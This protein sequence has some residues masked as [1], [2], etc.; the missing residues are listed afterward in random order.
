MSEPTEPATGQ[1]EL[2]ECGHSQ[3]DHKPCG[4]QDGGAKWV[5]FATD[6]KNIPVCDCESYRQIPKPTPTD[7]KTAR[8]FYEQYFGEIGHGGIY[9]A[10]TDYA[11]HVL[12]GA[13]SVDRRAIVDLLRGW[14]DWFNGPYTEGC[15]YINPPLTKT[16]AVL[17]EMGGDDENSKM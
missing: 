5:C 12:A 4:V 2:C 1:V 9:K 17:A 7:I 16:N 8:E 15:D 10:M 6:E 11:A 14:L 13:A 3:S